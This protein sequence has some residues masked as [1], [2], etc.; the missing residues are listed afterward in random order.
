MRWLQAI[1]MSSSKRSS[2]LFLR[3]GCE[4]VWLLLFHH[5]R[6]DSHTEQ[7][8]FTLFVKARLHQFRVTAT[9]SVLGPEKTA[10][11]MCSFPKKT[12][13]SKKS[14]KKAPFEG[15]LFFQ[16][17]TNCGKPQPTENYNLCFS[18]KLAKSLESGPRWPRSICI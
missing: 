14:E 3:E 15:F 13:S 11:I 5:F 7:P 17:F 8:S 4:V 16:I 10:L 18:C 9:Q 2:S 1:K 6:F 12:N